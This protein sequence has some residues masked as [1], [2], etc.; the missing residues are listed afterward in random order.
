MFPG[1]R[2]SYVNED[3]I[4]SV[5]QSGGVPIIIP[6][7]TKI[8][9]VDE[10]IKS[11]DALILSGGHDVSPIYYGE[12][13][14]QKL[15][16]IF[17]ER[18]RFEFELLRKAKEKNIPIMGICRGA[19]II[20]AYHGG[21]MYQDLSYCPSEVIKHWQ[22]HNPEMVTHTVGLVEDTLVSNLLEEKEVWVNS[23]HHQVIKN[24]P[25]NFVVSAESKD[26]VIE[27]IESKDYSFLLGV[28]W[29]PEMLHES[30]KMMNRL[31]DGLVKK[32]I[33][34]RKIEWQKA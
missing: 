32:A 27:A 16:D 33:E 11:I 10:V 18:D 25:E 28:Q 30:S 1:Y 22:E 15:G 12:E 17:P 6:V 26:G 9:V 29:H 23:F 3:Y 7:T 4:I 20:N 19:Q 21:T 31:F 8:E 2:R 5:I 13:P 14:Y 24:I 34:R